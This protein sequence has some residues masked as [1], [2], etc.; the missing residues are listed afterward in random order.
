M[1]LYKTSSVFYMCST[2]CREVSAADAL[3]TE[4]NSFWIHEI[5]SM[6]DF[7]MIVLVMLWSMGSN[8]TC[9]ELYIFSAFCKKKKEKVPVVIYKVAPISINA[10]N[11]E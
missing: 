7:L 10:S 2:Y 4:I 11:T 1:E 5:D 3:V 6:E 9:V 8:Y